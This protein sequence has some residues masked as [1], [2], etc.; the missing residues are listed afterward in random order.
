MPRLTYDEIKKSCEGRGSLSRGQG[1]V[2]NIPDHLNAVEHVTGRSVYI[3][4][5]LPYVNM[6]YA[7][8]VHSTEAVGIIDAVDISDALALPGVF[9]VYIASDVP[10]DNRIGA[11]THDEFVLASDRVSYIGQPVALVLG[12]STR[13]ARMGAEAVRVTITRGDSAPVLDPMVAHEKN[14]YVGPIRVITRGNPAKAI[15]RS[16]MTLAGMVENGG[17]EHM[18]LETQACRAVPQEDGSLVLH[19]SSQNPTEV[20]EMVAGALGMDRK[21]VTVEIKRM[22]GGFGG[23]EAQASNWATLAALGA[24]LSGRPVELVLERH[25]DGAF[26]GKRHPVK[27]G[28]RVGFEKDGT[29]TGIDMDLFLNCGA[30]ADLSIPVMGRAMSHVDNVYDVPNLKVTGYPCRTNL[31]PNTAFRGFGVPQGVYAMECVIHHVA[32]TLDK[33]PVEVRMKNLYRQGGVTHYGQ[34]VPDDVIGEI[35]DRLVEKSRYFERRKE[36][37][38]FNTGNPFVKKGLALVPVKFGISF[39]APH[40]NQAMALVLVYADGSVSVTHGGTEM[41]QEVNTKVAQ[42]VATE[43]GIDIGRIRIE[44]TN[45]T[46]IANVGPTAASTGT[47]LNGMA[48]SRAALQIRDRLADFAAQR[49][50][51]PQRGISPD[52]SSIIFEGNRVVDGRAPD[53]CM[54]WEKLVH[55]AYMARVD[56]GAHGFYA[57][58]GIGWNADT[59]KGNPFLYFACGAGVVEVMV[60][61][62]TGEYSLERVDI[63]HDVGESL[64]PAIDLG[65]VIGAF[66]QGVGWSTC[67]ELLWDASGRITTTSPATYKVPTIM[68]MPAEIDV[69][70]IENRRNTR[71]I[72]RSKAIGEPPLVYGEAAFFAIRDALRAL[73]PAG[74]RVELSLPATPEKVLMEIR[75]LR[76][77]KKKSGGRRSGR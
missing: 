34:I 65:Q 7:E 67:E 16:A 28:Y 46:R 3:S 51:S 36:I 9:A 45:T 26:T 44:A 64:N 49:L 60:D 55:M 59:G 31:P 17:Q 21:D 12:D 4:T 5:M 73:A 33:D 39:N 54:D 57:T 74:E 66:M 6:L 38:E 35:M 29:I 23:K 32:E 68:D 47:D 22:G 48:A 43:L 14:S 37:G 24:R 41:G 2:G 70:F 72:K 63:V 19:T 20:Q 71:N 69:E 52:P 75:R 11:L 56:L 50:N 27:T 13:T 53:L 25:R 8:V 30:F 42:I 10:G 62:I 40:L 18:Y 77:A 1:H 58:P 76:G 61:A 15:E